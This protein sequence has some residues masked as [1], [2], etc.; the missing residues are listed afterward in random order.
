MLAQVAVP[1]GT[2][3]RIVSHGIWALF[4]LLATLAHWHRGTVERIGRR[5]WRLIGTGLIAA[6]AYSSIQLLHVAFGTPAPGLVLV[7]LTVAPYPIAVIGIMTW[8]IAHRPRRVQALLDATIFAASVFFLT[9]AAGLGAV[10]HVTSLGTIEIILNLVWFGGATLLVGMVAYVGGRSFERLR[11]PLGFIGVGIL[12]SMICAALSARLTMTGVHFQ[13]HPIDLFWLTALLCMLLAALSPGSVTS[14]PVRE[15]RD[16]TSFAGD[17]IIYLPAAAVLVVS[18]IVHAADDPVMVAIIL[19]IGTAFFSRQFLALH[20]GRILSNQLERKVDERT[21]QLEASQ[22]ALV[23][24]ERMQAIGQVSAGI[25]H[26]FR[27]VLQTIYTQVEILQ[28]DAGDSERERLGTI[29]RAAES[30]SELA[31]SLIRI[32]KPGVGVPVALDLMQVVRGLEWLFRGLGSAG[33]SVDLGRLDAAPLHADRAQIEQVVSN[34]VVNARDAMPRGGHLAIET[35]VTVDG[36]TRLAVT[37]TGIGM[38]PGQI[39]RI[40]EP[41]YTTK[42][43]HHGTGLGLS[44]VYAVVTGL[45]GTINVQSAPGAGTTFEILLPATPPTPS[46]G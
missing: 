29:Q 37:D 6:T 34:L 20:D 22:A 23:R 36:W 13:A 40:F 11:G 41:F 31:R 32:G 9:W 14:P 7:L 35:G 10:V 38:T 24:G 18:L 16:P 28:L 4:G 30:G 44:T 33:I 21:R 1:G 19:L 3:G 26:D 8:P 46:S 5:G 27:N 15:D 45:S 2:T 39:A 25:A 17:L 12:I 43:D 42:A